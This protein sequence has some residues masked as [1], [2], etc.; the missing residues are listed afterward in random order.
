MVPHIC[1]A[2][3]VPHSRS[4]KQALDA[5]SESHI[6]IVNLGFW[7]RIA[8]EVWPQGEGGMTLLPWDWN[9]GRISTDASDLPALLPGDRAE[10]RTKRSPHWYPHLPFK[11]PCWYQQGSQLQCI[12]QRLDTQFCRGYK[13]SYNSTQQ[14]P[15]KI[16]GKEGSSVKWFV[17]HYCGLI[18]LALHPAKKRTF[19]LQY[20]PH[21]HQSHLCNSQFETCITRSD[22]EKLQARPFRQRYIMRN[23]SGKHLDKPFF[24]RS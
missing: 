10:D 15:T 4:P 5:E 6:R 14:P 7:S 20:V 18:W 12:T 1:G 13:V 3:F 16:G 22:M 21:T 11:Q 23:L 24:V 17:A 19:N 8:Q 9:D 2:P